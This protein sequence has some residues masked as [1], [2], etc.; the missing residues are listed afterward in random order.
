MDISINVIGKD[1]QEIVIKKDQ[2]IM[3]ESMT[4]RSEAIELAQLLTLAA[5]A[6]LYNVRYK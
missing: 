4:S 2:D 1:Y 3:I 6:I 5:S